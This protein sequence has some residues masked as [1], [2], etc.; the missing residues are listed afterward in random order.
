MY[1]HLDAIGRSI[2]WVNERRSPESA[3]EIARHTQ[4]NE[5]CLD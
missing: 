1:H 2:G 5:E 3:R 4:R